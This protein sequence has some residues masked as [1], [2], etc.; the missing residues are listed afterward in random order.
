M[1]Y[2]LRTYRIPAAVNRPAVTA[3]AAKAIARRRAGPPVRSSA[4]RSIVA[5]SADPTSE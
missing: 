3:S 1:R 2:E 5:I 4:R